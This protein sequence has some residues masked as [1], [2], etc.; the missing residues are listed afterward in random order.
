[1][2]GERFQRRCSE[3]TEV[4]IVSFPGTSKGSE[5][6][7]CARGHDVDDWLIIDTLTGRI[8]GAAGAK[9]GGMLKIGYNEKENQ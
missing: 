2:Q 1:M 5:R 7:N 6:M 4:E 3:H 8:I 9:L